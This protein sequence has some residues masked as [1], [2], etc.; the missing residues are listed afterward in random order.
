M[1]RNRRWLALVVSFA[2]CFGLAPPLAAQTQADSATIAIAVVDG[3]TQAPVPGAR[4]MLQGPVMTSEV[5]GADGKVTFADVPSGIYRARVVRAGYS[6]ATSKDFEVLP[7]RTVTVAVTL[8]MEVQGL[9]VIGRITVTSQPSPGPNDVGPDSAVRKLSDDLI[10]AIGQLPGVTVDDGLGNGDTDAPQTI[11]LDGHDP[12][13]T[14]L[15]LDGIPLNAPGTA[16]DLRSIASDLFASASVTHG[17]VVGALGGGVN[18]RTLEPTLTWQGSLSTAFGSYGNAH[19]TISER[20]TLGGIG[21]A[22]VHSVRGRDSLIAGERFADT[23]GVDT[24][25]GGYIHDGS[26]LYGGDMLKLRARLGSEQTLT[27]TYLSSRLYSD[28]VCATDTGPL[29]CGYGPGNAAYGHYAMY[30]LT[31]AAMLGVVGVQLSL[32]GID[33]T[34]DRDLLNRYVNGVA[35]PYGTNVDSHT[36]GL[37][38]NATLPSRGKHTFSVQATAE[39]SRQT[40]TP[41]IANTGVYLTSPTSSSDY[42]TLTLSD[43]VK[44]SARLR[45]AGR[46]GLSSSAGGR[47]ATLVGSSATWTPTIDDTFTGS[48]DLGD[49]G[50]APPRDGLLADPAALRFDCNGAVAYGYGPGDNAQPGSSLS[51]RGTWAHRFTRGNFN[52]TLYRQEQRG[53]LVSTLINASALP[54]GYFPPGYFAGAANAYNASCGASLAGFTPNDL[55][56]TIP[57]AGVTRV[58]QGIQL[59]GQLAVG[60]S[61]VLQGSY[62]VQSAVVA[63]GDPRINSPYSPTISGAQIAGV[64]LHTAAFLADYKPPR[65][66]VETLFDARYVSANNPENLPAYVTFDAGVTVQLRHGTLAFLG[67]NLFDTHGGFFATPGGVPLVTQNGTLLPTLQRPL[68]PRSYSVTYTVPLGAPAAQT[69]RTPAQL[70][71]GSQ[72]GSGGGYFEPLASAPP[73][74]PLAIDT[75]RPSCPAD[76]AGDARSILDAVGAYAA[77]LERAKSSD[78]YPSAPPP[79]APPIPYFAAAYHQSGSSYALT[80]IPTDVK[81]LRALARCAT[82]RVGT[83]TEAQQRGLYVPPPTPFGGF[84]LAFSPDAGLYAVRRPPTA[85]QE[86]F[87][88]YRLPSTPPARPFAV[89]TRPTCTSEAREIA[90]PLL[91][92]LAAYARALDPAHPPS[93]QPAGWHVDVARAGAAWWL[94]ARLAN[95]QTVPAV[96]DCAHVSG[97]SREELKS[98]GYDGGDPPVLNFTPAY[99]LYVVRNES[100]GRAR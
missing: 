49:T 14:A 26:R 21:I 81:G 75:Q 16:G 1:H 83:E 44:S 10:G 94:E 61:L 28:L 41:E 38:L 68:T 29:P 52:A 80:L 57:I 19:T 65:S 53:A 15:T 76:V 55:Y 54:G 79:D 25:F 30:S 93:A 48:V 86:Q 47:T 99:G 31:D 6:S 39:H 5:A 56:L 90:Q 46:V 63:S 69:Q 13:Q 100:N 60:P 12:S 34:H 43:S 7:G 91:D 2:V 4:V 84:A 96:L 66:A 85:G 95:I 37:N 73:K 23:S 8:S 72:R 97:A 64:P 9:K 74:N 20:G 32:F 89:E 77:A 92:A 36:R 42:S 33:S 35:D 18:F 78:A 51:L 22:Y 87:R 98:H 17:P 27:A 45:L 40:T 88:L 70:G 82:V 11:S 58:Y 59:G 50:A 3:S 62:V 24:P 67:Q 71:E